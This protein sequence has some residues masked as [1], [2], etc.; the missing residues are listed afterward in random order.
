MPKSNDLTL[1]L[2]LSAE[3]VA[4][5]K[6]FCD[7][8]DFLKQAS[9]SGADVKLLWPDKPQ[10]Q[11]TTPTPPKPQP[12]IPT[13]PI[14]PKQAANPMPAPAASV[15]VCGSAPTATPAI[16]QQPAPTAAPTYSMDQIARAGAEL[17]QAGKTPQLLGLLQQFNVQAVTQIPKAQ[18]GAFATALRGLGA[19]L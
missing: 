19:Q 5:M 4:L 8:I 11:G 15:P 3:N 13:A 18:Y 16:P 14:A 17:A 6:R 7:S 12:A 10:T 9:T 1:G 2:T